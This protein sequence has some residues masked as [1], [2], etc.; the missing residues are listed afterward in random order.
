MKYITLTLLIISC[1]LPLRAEH[2]VIINESRKIMQEIREYMNEWEER[3]NPI[4]DN[5][6]VLKSGIRSI[7]LNKSEE[8]SECNAL[9]IK[10]KEEVE[11]L[12]IIK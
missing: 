7:I 11:K 10:M 1:A 5:V 8:V 6:T 4:E 9:I 3:A 12:K 2:N